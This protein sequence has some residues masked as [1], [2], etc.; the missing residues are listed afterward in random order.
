[1]YSWCKGSDGSDGIESVCG[2]I[3]GVKAVME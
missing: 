2:C 3:L 1:M